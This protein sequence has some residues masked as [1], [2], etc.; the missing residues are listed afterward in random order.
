MRPLTVIT[1]ILLGSSLAITVSL[2]AVMLVFLIVGDDSPRVQDELRPLLS[3]IS[4]FFALT[5]ISAASF[6]T[7]VINHRSRNL[8]QLL[9]WAGIAA[10]AWYYIP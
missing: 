3:S 6:Y 2:A 10:T 5:V 1:G 4:I 9:L 8:C 7:L